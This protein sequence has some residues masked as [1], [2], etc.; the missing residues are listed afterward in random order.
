MHVL[1]KTEVNRI[2]LSVTEKSPENSVDQKRRNLKAYSD[3][4]VSSWSDTLAA[5]RKARL[6]WKEEKARNE[7]EERIKIDRK[8][9]VLQE[10]ARQEIL[11]NSRRQMFEQ[12]DKVKRLR[13]Q[14]LY[15]NVIEERAKQIA[16]SK[17][18]ECK[19]NIEEKVWYNNAIE[20]IHQAE[21]KEREE[22]KARKAKSVEIARA[23]RQQRQD[24][25]KEDEKRRR[26]EVEEGK[27]LKQIA[28]DDLVDEQKKALSKIEETKR[29]NASIVKENQNLKRIY[30]E[31]KI[32]EA[33]E[34]EK[35]KR[36][37]AEMNRL[38]LGRVNLEKKLF[39]ERQAVRKKMIDKAI[40]DLTE[41]SEKEVEL[42][43]MEHKKLTDAANAKED[44][45]RKERGQLQQE[46]DKS[47]QE[48]IK[49]R[50]KRLENERKDDEIFMKHL[51][52]I[53]DQLLLEEQEKLNLR[54]TQNK[55][56]RNYQENQIKDNQ[57]RRLEERNNEIRYHK[58][59]KGKYIDLFLSDFF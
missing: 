30:E 45:E 1:S 40:A 47:R 10:H 44:R 14:Q 3:K 56:L 43:V 11:E 4:R 12:V 36:E 49:E 41:R 57:R 5:K 39:D 22:E 33:E 21:R 37:V 20:Q 15:I 16:Q 51:Q 9:A 59:V 13:S 58:K 42:F 54:R 29:A 52:Q 6:K 35:L 32:A 19:R 17:E 50:K 25:L 18:M 48:Q 27:R 38:A 34:D 31:N 26:E 28:I 2:R 23:L 24:T 53:N 46:I 8:E 55:E 7:E